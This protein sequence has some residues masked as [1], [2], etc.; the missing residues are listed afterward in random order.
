MTLFRRSLKEAPTNGRQELQRRPCRYLR[1][2]RDAIKPLER[3]LKKLQAYRD[4]RIAVLGAY[5]KTK[6]DRL[7]T[8]AGLSV[9]DVVAL[10]PRLGPQ[11]PAGKPAAEDV[12]N[13]CRR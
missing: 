2:L 13:G 6:A 8:S 10:V 3:R 9:I 1:K 12:A 11:A 7:A 4:K 5:E